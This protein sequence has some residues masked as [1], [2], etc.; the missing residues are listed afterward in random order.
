MRE[1][2]TVR[3]I[4]EINPIENADAIEVATVDGWEVVIRKGEYNVGAI[5]VFCEIDSW[6][7]T[8]LAPFLSKGKTPRMY[9]GVVG[10]RLRTIKLR[11]QI[12]QGLILSTE[13][14]TGFWDIGE[15]VTE[16][17]NILKY[18]PP[19]NANLA[20]ISRGNFPIEFPKTN[21]ARIQ[22]CSKYLG[23][24]LSEENCF[25]VTEKL[26]GS[27]MTCFLLDDVFGVCSKNINLKESEGNSFWSCARRL[28]IER[29][30][31]E[32]GYE[33][34]AL[35]GELI[36]PGIQKNI[37]KLKQTDFK[38]FD[39]ITPKGPRQPT[40]R[41]SLLKSMDIESVPVLAH[42]YVNEEFSTMKDIILSADGQSKLYKTKREG[43]V[44]KHMT[45]NLSFKV[46]SNT[47]LLKQDSL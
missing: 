4:T 45:A 24:W 44:F 9:E 33:N 43:L 35:Q 7:P 19:V 37:Y 10:E 21:Q 22:N 46:I 17:L 29:K 18:D 36:G 11:G 26:E 28:D 14:L 23:K 13:I 2:A 5:I 30:M 25:E 41:I 12:S 15:D 20:G 8:E 31:R 3:M 47:Y 27:S 1:M 32:S 40:S 34:F 6:M 38:V 42:I 16:Q 39:I